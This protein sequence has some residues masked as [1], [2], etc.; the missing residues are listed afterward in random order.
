MTN[1]RRSPVS[2]SQLP[3]L[4]PGDAS[5]SREGIGRSY[6]ETPPSLSDFAARDRRGCQGNLQHLASTRGFQWLHL[7][8]GIGSYLTAPLWLIFLVLEI[9]V[10][11]QAQFVRPEYFPKGF[12]LFPKWT[13]AGSGPRGMGV[14][15]N[16]GYAACAEAARFQCAS[17]Q[18]R[19]AKAVRGW[20]SKLCRHPYRNDPFRPDRASY[21]ALPIYSRSTGPARP[22]C[23]L[24]RSA[25]RRWPRIVQEHR[26]HLFRA[27]APR[28]RNGRQ[29]L[30]SI[31]TAAFLD[32]ASDPGPVAGYSHRATAGASGRNRCRT[33]NT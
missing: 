29:C 21:D 28:N 13:G 32:A 18:S 5:I 17:W 30:C 19:L 14:C 26:Q 11:L 4:Q 16:H 8:T 33:A 1:S 3:C 27:D 15:R 24:A 10:S 20:L 12:S 6:E 31:A 22:R 9:L 25:T 2:R 7:L 23:G